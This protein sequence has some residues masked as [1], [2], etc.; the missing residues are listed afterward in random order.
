MSEKLICYNCS[1]DTSLLA[2]IEYNKAGFCSVCGRM[3][4]YLTE[5]IAKQERVQ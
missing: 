1:D 4:K 2:D 3:S 5:I